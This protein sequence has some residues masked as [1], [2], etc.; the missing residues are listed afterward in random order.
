[1][2]VNEVMTR[3]VECIRPDATLQEAAERMKALDIGPLPVCDDDRLVGMLTDR[4]LVLRA[5]AEGRDPR[6]TRVRDTMTPDIVYC[7]E[8]QDVREAARLMK[9]KQI[10]RL[11]VLNRDKRL[12]GIL[13]LGDLAVDTGDEQLAG[14]TLEQISEPATPRG[15]PVGSPEF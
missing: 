6:T 7:F 11:V 4:D 9:E 5:V 10:R 1:M 15:V 13:S 3:G 12:V 2:R 14:E 8:D